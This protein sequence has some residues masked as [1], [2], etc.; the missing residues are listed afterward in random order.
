VKLE[1]RDY[2]AHRLSRARNALRMA[3]L[4]LGE[5]D[6]GLLPDAVNRLYYACFYAVTALLYTE[7]VTA[8]RHTGLISLFGEHWTGPERFS[9]GLGRFLHQMFERRLEGDYG[10]E[11]SFERSEVE[12][13]IAEAKAFVT[14]IEAY[15]QEHPGATS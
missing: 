5:E 2:L 9:R 15:L 4:A 10:E 14:Q 1:R 7:G 6:D 11:A 3:E 12:S 13:W 8:S